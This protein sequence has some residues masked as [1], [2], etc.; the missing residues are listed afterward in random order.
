MP[1]IILD[2]YVFVVRA[3][4]NMI[5]KWVR[6]REERKTRRMYSI[7]LAITPACTHNTCSQLTSTTHDVNDH[8]SET[9]PPSRGLH[10]RRQQLYPS[11]PPH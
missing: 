7:I 2:K 8:D 6:A 11:C 1:Q 4:I 10:L 9:P 5:Q 3:E